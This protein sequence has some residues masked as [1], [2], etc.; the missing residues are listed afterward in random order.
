MSANIPLANTCNLNQPWVVEASDSKISLKTRVTPWVF[1][2][3]AIRTRS[4][5]V[6]LLRSIVA[7]SGAIGQSL[8]IPHANETV[9]VQTDQ[10]HF[11]PGGLLDYCLH[12]NT[13]SSNGMLQLFTRCG[14]TIHIAELPNH[15]P[16]GSSFAPSTRYLA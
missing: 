13:Y 16:L 5:A 6:L 1:Q 10:L 8:Q 15:Y 3:L 9:P 2:K 11:R 12:Y 14:A 4:R 7:F